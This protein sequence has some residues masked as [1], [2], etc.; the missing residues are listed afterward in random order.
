MK[1]VSSPR[2]FH[3]G[4][5]SMPTCI[6]AIFRS[7][8]ILRLL[9]GSFCSILGIVG[10]AHRFLTRNTSYRISWA[11]FPARLPP[12]R[13]NC[14]SSRGW[15]PAKT[16]VG[17]NWNRPC[18]PYVNP[19]FDRPL[20]GDIAGSGVD[21]VVPDFAPFS[22][23]NPA[24]NWCCLQ[25][26]PCSTSRGLGA[27]WI[28]KWICGEQRGHSLKKWMKEQVGPPAPDHTMA[29]A[30]AADVEAAPA[31]APCC[32]TITWSGGARAQAAQTANCSSLMQEQ[33]PD[34]TG[35]CGVLLY[36][37]I[38]LL[39]RAM[40]AIVLLPRLLHG[41]SVFSERSQFLATLRLA[42]RSKRGVPIEGALHGKKNGGEAVNKII[43]Y[44]W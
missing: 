39:W 25:K 5:F 10:N 27:N 13:R 19:V 28:Q 43:F 18:A 29:Q 42:G 22:G 44:S 3:D 8:P 30:V 35:C 32:F 11:F 36:A 14:T 24:A 26:K 20:R 21:A 7:A 4:F 23:G 16:R 15:V 2:S 17:R 6:L 12:Y 34:Q 37:A 31:I 40:I 33:R 38:G 9:D 41:F 1:T